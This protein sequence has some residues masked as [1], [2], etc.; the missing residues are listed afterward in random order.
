LLEEDFVVIG[1]LKPELVVRDIKLPSRG[2]QLATKPV[3][4]KQLADAAVAVGSGVRQL[5]RV[6]LRHSS[7]ILTLSRRDLLSIYK[8]RVVPH[9]NRLDRC[10][11]MILENRPSDSRHSLLQLLPLD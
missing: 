4:G 10:I 2:L 5:V 3:G 8:L 7:N 1:S 6:L 11:S 9:L